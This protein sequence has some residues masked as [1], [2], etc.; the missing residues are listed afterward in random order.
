MSE[1]TGSRVLAGLATLGGSLTLAFTGVASARTTAARDAASTRAFIGSEL[2]IDRAMLAHGPAELAAGRA[3]LT[4]VR[5]ECGSLRVHVPRKPGAKGFLRFF[6]FAIE[7]V[8]AYEDKTVAPAR[9]EIDR[10]GRLQAGLRFSDPTLQWSVHSSTSAL[11]AMLALKPPDICADARRLAATKFKQMTPAG[12]EFS[13][14]ALTLVAG[15]TGEPGL[16]HKMRPYAPATVATGLQRLNSLDRRV[17]HLPAIRLAGKLFR[18][19]FG[20]MTSKVSSGP[21]VRSVLG[22]LERARL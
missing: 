22:H 17:T 20:P 19:L 10:I 12:R 7:V 16:L 18:E 21:Q 2:G 13:T 9:P 4:S 11:P 8:V 3:Y 1:M 15:Q 5:A 14:D 6:G